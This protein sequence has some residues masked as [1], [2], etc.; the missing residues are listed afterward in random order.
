ML[1]VVSYVY[2][3]KFVR[4][5]CKFEVMFERSDEEMFGIVAKGA[6]QVSW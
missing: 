6:N 1:I 3:C 5:E 4:N 2:E